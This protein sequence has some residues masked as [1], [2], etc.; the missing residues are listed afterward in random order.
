MS[1]LKM[2]QNLGKNR[3]RN[4]SKEDFIFLLIEENIILCL[5]QISTK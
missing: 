5:T 4:I 2:P 1:K 3:H